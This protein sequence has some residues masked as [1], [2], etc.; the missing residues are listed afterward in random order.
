M[1]PTYKIIMIEHLPQTWGRGKDETPTNNGVWKH[2][3]NNNKN[4]NSNNNNIWRAQ[5]KVGLIYLCKGLFSLN[6][7]MYYKLKSGT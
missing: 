5:V 3:N 2:V 4:N 7:R 6:A 1:L